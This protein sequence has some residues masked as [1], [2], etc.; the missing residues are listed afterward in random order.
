MN[1][2]P[3]FQAFISESTSI[4]QYRYCFLSIEHGAQSV[5]QQQR[6]LRRC[7]HHCHRHSHCAAAA[8][9]AA[10]IGAMQRT[11]RLCVRSCGCRGAQLWPICWNGR[12]AVVNDNGNDANDACSSLRAANANFLADG[13]VVPALGCRC[14]RVVLTVSV[15]ALVKYMCA[16]VV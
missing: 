10:P 5:T 2:A 12:R 4:P 7:C 1:C 11:L 15:F 16:W 6:S 14:V 3:A 9:A 8:A 13:D